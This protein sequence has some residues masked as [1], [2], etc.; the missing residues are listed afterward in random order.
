MKKVILILTLILSISAYSQDRKEKLRQRF[1][2]IHHSNI[3]SLKN[4]QLFNKSIEILNNEPDSLIF[5]SRKKL[6]EIV[7]VAYINGYLYSKETSK[8]NF[9]ALNKELINTKNSVLNNK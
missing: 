5:I 3:D 1:D 8:F 9:E 4:R 6:L 2:N 7:F